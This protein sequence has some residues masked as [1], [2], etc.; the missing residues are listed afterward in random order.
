MIEKVSET[1][2]GRGKAGS[3]AGTAMS[4]DSLAGDPGMYSIGLGS[5]ATAAGAG[6]ATA[7]G[8]G[9]ATGAGGLLRRALDRVGRRCG[10]RCSG[11][12]LWCRRR[13]DC[14]PD[15]RCNWCCRR[16]DDWRSRDQGTYRDNWHRAERTWSWDTD[17]DDR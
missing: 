6:A 10:D 5:A 7:A 9:A 11:R 1:G 16:R 8:A 14:W 13:Y 2:S 17:Y 12:R 4:N 15:R 3:V